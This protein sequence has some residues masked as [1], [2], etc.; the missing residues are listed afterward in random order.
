ML[1]V[2][3]DMDECLYPF[4]RTLDR[5]VARKYGIRPKQSCREYVFAKRYPFTETQCKHIVRD[6]YNSKEYL[7]APPIEG[8]VEALV[9]LK[10]RY[11]LVCVT[12]RQRYAKAATHRFLDA[13]MPNVFERVRF[14][15]S[16]SLEGREQTK[17]SVCR[18]ERAFV[19]I[20]DNPKYIDECKSDVLTLAFTGTP[21]YPWAYEKDDVPSFSHWYTCP[22]FRRA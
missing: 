6:F 7:H 1:T 22:L 9:R 18:E 12:G 2:A 3:V 13:H 17:R 8:S 16:F 5:Y 14:T 21:R 19:L 15:N 11:R 4:V 10:R 20:D